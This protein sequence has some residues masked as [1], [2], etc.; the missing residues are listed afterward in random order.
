MRNIKR[1]LLQSIPITLINSLILGVIFGIS[2]GLGSHV[3]EYNTVTSILSGFVTVTLGVEIYLLICLSLTFLFTDIEV[4]EEV[5]MGE[6][7]D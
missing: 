4:Y 5:K 2:I 3:Q 1:R 7:Y 6:G